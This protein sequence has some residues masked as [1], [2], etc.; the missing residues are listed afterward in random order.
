MQW[1][2][3]AT[4]GNCIPIKNIHLFL[5]VICVTSKTLYLKMGC[6]IDLMQNLKCFIDPLIQT[7][8]SYLFVTVEYTDRSIIDLQ[9]WSQITLHGWGEQR[10]ICRQNAFLSTSQSLPG[11]QG[12]P[13]QRSRESVFTG[14]LEPQGRKYPWRRGRAPGWLPVIVPVPQR[15]LQCDWAGSSRV[16]QQ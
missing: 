9:Y 16:I 6:I 7:H 4:Q 1:R 12:G 15:S 8:M 13:E 3:F 10:Q 2:K 14:S 11:S 5:L